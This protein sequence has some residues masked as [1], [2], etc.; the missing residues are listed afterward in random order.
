[1]H[2]FLVEGSSRLLNQGD[3]VAK[4][5]AKASGGFDA[6]VRYKTDQDDFLDAPLGELGV[7]IGI[8]KAALRPVL[9]HDDVAVAR[10]EF[11][12]ELTAPSSGGE[13]LGLVHP[14]LAWIHMFP[15][16]IVAFSPAV[17]RHDDDL[18]TRRSDHG[19][20]L[21]HVVVEADCFSR[22]PGRLVE[23]A[24][25][26]HEIVIG[27]NDQQRGAVCGVG[28]GCHELPPTGTCF[29]QEAPL[30]GYP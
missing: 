1:M 23:L 16:K 8:G 5:H 15:P 17:M 29:S 30:N 18:D 22:L 4:L 13:A 27:I 2:A 3:V 21:A 12:M 26:T 9:E 6:G 7:E 11:R 14:N 25:F 20:Q 28:G 10:A 19:N 24:A